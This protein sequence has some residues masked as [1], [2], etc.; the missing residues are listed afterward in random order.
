MG[1]CDVTFGTSFASL[2][3]ASIRS[4]ADAV[5][6]LSP[7]TSIENSS[8]MTHSLTIISPDDSAD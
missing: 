8:D 5:I 7:G 2:G 1:A 6:R 4:G 3:G